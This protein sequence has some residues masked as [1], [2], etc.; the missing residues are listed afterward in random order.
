MND[1]L[2][3]AGAAFLGILVQSF[4]GFGGALL[5]LLL[6][7]RLAVPTYCL[8]MVIVQLVLMLEA[9][10][11]IRWPRVGLLLIGGLTGGA[12]GACGLAKLPTNWIAIAI[13]AITL[14]FACLFLFRVR[15]RLKEN[16]ASHVCVGFLGGLLGGSTSQSGPP[17]V[18]FGLARGWAKDSFRATLIAYFFFLSLGLTV[19]YLCLGLTGKKNLTM[20]ALSLPLAFLA[21]MLGVF[22]KRRASEGVYRYAVLGVIILVSLTGLVMRSLALAGVGPVALKVSSQ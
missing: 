6:S 3:F 21:A 22:I 17:V 15:L 20:C 13:S 9:R 19:L 8:L 1:V 12:I 11:H 4:V 5:T 2:L 14:S 10:R 18:L 16:V 7:P